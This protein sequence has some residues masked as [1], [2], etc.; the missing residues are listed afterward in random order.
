MCKP[1]GALIIG[2]LASLLNVLGYKYLTP[3]IQKRLRIHDTC[4]VHNL[5]GM[6][7]VL[8]GIF[9]A[10]MAALATENSYDYSLYEEKLGQIVDIHPIDD[11]VPAV[12]AK[13]AQRIVQ[14]N[15]TIYPIAII[16]RPCDTYY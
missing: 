4:G 14:R 2:S 6:P 11:V 7:G 16:L 3:F 15:A 5:H 12:A 9:G 1:I 8:A 13:T 10:I